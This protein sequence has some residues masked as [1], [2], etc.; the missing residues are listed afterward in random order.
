MCSLGPLGWW[1]E[2]QRGSECNTRK[3]THIHCA[4]MMGNHTTMLLD[5]LPAVLRATHRPVCQCKAHDLLFANTP[6]CC[7]SCCAAAV[8]PIGFGAVPDCLVPCA[9]SG[10]YND[11]KQ[12]SCQACPKGQTSLDGVSC[13][14][15]TCPA[16]YELGSTGLC[17]NKC[18]KG[19]AQDG[20]TNK[21]R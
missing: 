19:W 12:T 7:N 20:T 18:N 2:W 8:C 21:C 9:N 16:G 10:Q 4:T 3:N 5:V 17:N 14:L 11:G 1:S 6:S 13:G 15:A